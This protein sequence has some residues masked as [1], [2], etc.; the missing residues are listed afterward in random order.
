MRPLRHSIA[1]VSALAAAPLFGAALL[2]RPAWRIG[3]RERLGATASVGPASIW[4]HAASLG[5]TRAAHALARALAAQGETLYLSHT[6]ADALKLPFPVPV[7]DAEDALVGRGVAPLDHPWCVGQALDTLQPR[8]IVLV[9]TELWPNGI[10]AAVER[11]VA[12]GVVSASISDRSFERYRRLSRL[13]APTFER[14]SFVGARSEDDADRFV[15]LGTAPERVRVTGDLKRDPDAATDARSAPAG[16]VASIAGRPV[17]LAGSTHEGEEAAV[18]EAYQ[19]ARAQHPELLC[20]V[21][22]RRLERVAEIEALVRAA[23]L[24]VRLRSA[25]DGSPLALGEVLILDTL[26]ELAACYALA[27][28]AFVGGSL[29]AVGGHNLYEP[30]RAGAFVLHGP[31]VE[32]SAEAAR[33]LKADGRARCVSTTAEFANALIDALRTSGLRRLAGGG[34]IPGMA[35]GTTA[36]TT[37][38]FVEEMS[39]KPQ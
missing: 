35:S 25:E 36:A 30:A 26:G 32:S 8:A 17:L 4:L 18:V 9:E 31:H 24:N 2:L 5:E 14:L 21:A 3:W 33:E 16:V 11:G 19:A 13:M 20:V 12:V 34:G 15:V 28:V 7:G 23:G 22:P 38:A 37:A 29:V 27:S 10:R 1:A 6:R 39:G